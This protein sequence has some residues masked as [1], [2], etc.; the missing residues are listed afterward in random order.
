M[1][2]WW[3]KCSVLARK[4]LSIQIRH[5]RGKSCNTIL[6]FVKVVRTRTGI[7]FSWQR[8]PAQRLKT[9]KEAMNILPLRFHILGNLRKL[10]GQPQRK[11]RSAEGFMNI[12]MVL[13][14]P[15]KS[16][17]I[18]LCTFFAVFCMTTTRKDQFCVV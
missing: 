2:C 16:L 13:H 4:N 9:E 12:T 1:P 14:V 11:H 3:S 18:L 7:Q 6:T 15:Y 8:K 5:C 10:R 17:Y